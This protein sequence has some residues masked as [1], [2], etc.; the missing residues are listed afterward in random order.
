MLVAVEPAM[1]D[2][3]G[4]MLAALKVLKVA[5][6]RAA[7]ERMLATRPL[8]VV[9]GKRPKRD[10]LEALRA[11]A[12]DISAQVVVLE[13]VADPTK[14]RLEVAAALRAAETLR[15]GA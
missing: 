11:T 3:L 10:E 8:V 7:C 1:A 5:H 2:E 12:L 15:D 9:V 6:V 4:E 13:N 14:R